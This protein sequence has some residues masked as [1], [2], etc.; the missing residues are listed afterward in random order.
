MPDG[1]ER[2]SDVR[3]SRI[4]YANG[5]VVVW[6]R[7]FGCYVA[8]R[9]ANVPDADRAVQAAEERAANVADADRAVQAAEQSDHAEEDLAEHADDGDKAD[10]AEH[11][12]DGGK[13]ASGGSAAAPRK[14]LLQSL[15]KRARSPVTELREAVENRRRMYPPETWDSESHKGA[16]SASSQD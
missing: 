9:R 10:L 15:L 6:S 11:A 2:L 7:V 4:T 12:D 13:A 5:R 16:K 1:T 3:P 8:E 14:T